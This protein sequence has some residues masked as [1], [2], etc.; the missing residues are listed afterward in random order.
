MKYLK[1]VQNAIFALWMVGVA[2]LLWADEFSDGF[3]AASSGD[4][5]SAV[6][7]WKPLAK[8]G[9]PDAQFNLAL[10]LHSGANGVMDEKEA[11]KLY[12]K[13][14]KNG[15]RNAQQYLVAAYGEGWFGLKKDPKKATFWLNKLSER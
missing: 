10:I 3:M 2:P 15:H 6:S 7:A 12:H 14:A 8:N 4:Y 11:V 1:F 9:H 13:A 5:K